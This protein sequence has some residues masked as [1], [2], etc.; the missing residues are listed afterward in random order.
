MTRGEADGMDAQLAAVLQPALGAVHID[1]LVRLTG[2]ASRET[3][4]FDA[5]ADDGSRTPLILQR[6]RPGTMMGLSFHVEDRL[7]AAAAARGVPIAEVVVD[8]AGCVSLGDGRITR[9]IDGEALGPKLVR[10]AEWAPVRAVLPA[11][12]AHALAAIHS[13]PLDGLE[14]TD[15]HEGL[16]EED[17]VARLRAGIDQVE[18]IS[19]AFE[20]AMRWL[21]DHRPVDPR[22]C[23]VH[24]DFRIGNLLVD[25]SGLRAVLDWEL[26]QV[27][28]PV[29]DL[30]WLCLRAWRFGG[31]EPVGGIGSLEAFLADY[32]DASGFTVDLEQFRWWM[33]AGTLRWGLIC[34]VQAH[35]HLDGHIRSVELA[36]IGRRVAE[37]EHDLL[38]LLRVAPHPLDEPL[39]TVDFGRPS[40]AELVAAVR[41]H[42]DDELLS[43]LSRG[44]AFGM[45]VVRHA[46][47]IVERELA[48]SVPSPA[49]D[50][51]TLAARIRGGDALSDAELRQVRAAVA[52]RISVANPG[53]AAAS[54]LVDIAAGSGRDA[55][56]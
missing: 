47:A 49:F 23:V 14:T 34:A 29:S 24:G 22:R 37:N 54:A 35:R 9:R 20:L 30:A 50:E 39:P 27:G 46:L 28:D 4:S 31:P 17:V 5:V 40:A 51:P 55:G 33:L 26:A 32:E 19:P 18:V 52:A 7:L 41:G 10:G 21:D 3:W 56:A 44:D 2:G 38:D 43:R 25:P 48:A 8:A 42:F 16:V 12:M 6:A 45:R 15:G 36:S 11:Q 53:W 13:I 1:G